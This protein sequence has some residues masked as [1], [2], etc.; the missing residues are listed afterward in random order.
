MVCYQSTA[1]VTYCTAKLRKIGELSK[2][3]VKFLAVVVPH[4]LVIIIR[5]EVVGVGRKNIHY[6]CVV[7]GI[8]GAC[9][10]VVGGVDYQ[11]THPTR[12]R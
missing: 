1:G 2:L 9:V 10:V 4:W 12:Q 5:G 11:P 8:V 7:V 6:C 3:I